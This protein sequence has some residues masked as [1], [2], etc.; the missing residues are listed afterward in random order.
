[1]YMAYR[2]ERQNSALVDPEVETLGVLDKMKKKKQKKK[3]QTNKSSCILTCLFSL[4]ACFHF[5]AIVYVHARAQ[6][7][8]L[9]EFS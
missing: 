2:K 9:S 5:H 4:L 3:K 8:C 7:S 1:M 6:F